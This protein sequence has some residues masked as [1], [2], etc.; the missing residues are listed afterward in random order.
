[1]ECFKSSLT[2]GRSLQALELGLAMA[3]NAFYEN[4]V[5]SEF[6]KSGAKGIGGY[7]GSDVMKC[8]E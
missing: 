5:H 8:V 7:F 2:L 1:M 3:C 4:V 6:R